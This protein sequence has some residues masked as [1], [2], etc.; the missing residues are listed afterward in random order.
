MSL[1]PKNIS[2]QLLEIVANSDF[3]GCPFCGASHFN[4][5]S[6]RSEQM[7]EWL[8]QRTR[9]KECKEEWCEQ[10]KRTVIITDHMSDRDVQ[11]ALGRRGIKRELETFDKKSYCVCALDP[12]IHGHSNEC[13]VE[14]NGK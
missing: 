14:S 13:S 3:L 11:N 7:D 1:K 5:I 4:V 12:E 8:I 9:C 2:E 10:F 6:D